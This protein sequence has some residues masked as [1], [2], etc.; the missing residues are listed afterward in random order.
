LN[1][2]KNQEPDMPYRFTSINSNCG[3]VF[4]PLEFNE[5]N[6]WENILINCSQL[7]KYEQKLDRVVGMISYYNPEGNYH[8]IYWT[9]I[10]S[11]WEYNE[12]LEKIIENDFPLRSVKMEKIFRYYL[13]D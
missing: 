13:K 8:D 6:K 10:N 4:I 2:V 7:H 12:E 11:N 9:C 1:K 3:F 5:K